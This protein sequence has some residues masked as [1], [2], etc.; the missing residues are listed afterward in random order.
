MHHSYAFGVLVAIWR[1]VWTNEKRKREVAACISRET[2]KQP[3]I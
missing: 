3:I 1:L 2:N